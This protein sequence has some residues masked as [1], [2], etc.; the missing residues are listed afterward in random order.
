MLILKVANSRHLKT[1]R[2]KQFSPLH[3]KNG[4]ILLIAIGI[5]SRS[6]RYGGGTFAHRDLAFEFGGWLSPEFILKKTD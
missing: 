5:Q 4:S 3:Q 1:S 2:I 6:G